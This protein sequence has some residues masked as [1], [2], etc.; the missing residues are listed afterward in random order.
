MSENNRCMG[1]KGQQVLTAVLLTVV[2]LSVSS[3]AYVWGKEMLAKSRD[4]RHFK[5]MERSIRDLN[6]NI[7]EV[8]R[9]GGRKEMQIDL[10]DDGELN[11][12]DAG[13][14]GLDNI[15]LDFPVKGQKMALDD[16]VAIKGTMGSEAPITTEPDVITAYS[17]G[18]GDLYNIRFKIYYKNM[19]VEGEP[20]NRIGIEP[21]GRMTASGET[22]SITVEDG[23]TEEHNGLVV[24][25]VKVRIS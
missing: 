4:Q 18:T 24:N 22:T 3:G 1:N 16:E 14:A 25:K 11:I 6:E 7:K 13:P 19:T 12:N 20:S 8:A 9:R 17:T 23:P 21:T 5:N 2:I 15:T 10:P